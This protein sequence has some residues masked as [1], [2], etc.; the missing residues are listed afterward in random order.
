M[1]S[2]LLLRSFP[3]WKALSKPQR[4]L[5][6]EQLIHPSTVRWPLMVTKWLLF[7]CAMVGIMWSDIFDDSWRGFLGVVI[8]VFFLPE[9]VDLIVVA[10]MRQKIGRYIQ[11]HALEIQSAA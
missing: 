10:R 1:L 7:S 8:T 9:I 6:W 4:K 2:H 5:V 11:E 3:P